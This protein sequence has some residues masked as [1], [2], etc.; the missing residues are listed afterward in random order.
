MCNE[1]TILIVCDPSVARP[2]AA[3]AEVA[4][5]LVA[6]TEIEGETE[7][8]DKRSKEKEGGATATADDFLSHFLAQIERVSRYKLEMVS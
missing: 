6:V 7:G 4:D 5:A 2:K 8:D 3:M 1:D